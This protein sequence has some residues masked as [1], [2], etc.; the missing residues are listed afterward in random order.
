MKN[1]KFLLLSVTVALFAGCASTSTTYVDPAGSRTIANVDRINVQDFAQA[2]DQMV[3]SLIDNVIN[4]NALQSGALGQPALMAI[5]RVQNS[6]GHQFDTDLLVKKIRVRL[7][8]TGRIQT[9]TTGNLG[10]AE[11]PLAADLQRQKEFFGDEKHPRSPD[12]TLSG[13]I[14]EDRTRA[15]RVRQSAFVFQL[16]LSSNSGIAIWEDEKTIIKQGKKPSVGF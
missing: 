13:K 6:T 16:S 8:N 7:L 3:N 14:I 2:A 12:Y 10:E 1:V 5:S 4:Q 9:T 15:G 11:D